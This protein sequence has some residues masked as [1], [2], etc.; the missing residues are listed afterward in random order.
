MLH[1]WLLCQV[2]LQARWLLQASPT[3]QCLQDWK[4][5][6]QHQQMQMH[7]EL[8]QKRQQQELQK[9]QQQLLC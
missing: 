2:F 7:H 5:Q 9:Q 8:Q 6:H 3:R 1:M 4:H